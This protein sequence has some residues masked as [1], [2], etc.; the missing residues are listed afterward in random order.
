MTKDIE[1]PPPPGVSSGPVTTNGWDPTDAGSGNGWENQA[2]FG[3]D[4]KA[5]SSMSW[6]SHR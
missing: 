3:Y 4:D 2:L 5:L 1:A 6:F